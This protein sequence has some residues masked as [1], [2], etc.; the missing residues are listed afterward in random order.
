MSELSRYKEALK[1][2]KRAVAV[3]PYYV[4]C[5]CNI[6]VIYKHRGHLEEA[7]DSYQKA[8]DINPNFVIA[9]DNMAIAL[10]DLGTD[11]KE[12]GNVKVHF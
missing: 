1:F 9:K 11:Y 5:H 6:G 10:T 4:E 12:K 2:Y 8:L 3:N 7:I